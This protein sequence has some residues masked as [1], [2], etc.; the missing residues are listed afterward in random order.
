V[1]LARKFKVSIASIKRIAEELKTTPDDEEKP[2]ILDFDTYFELVNCESAK[3]YV[4]DSGNYYGYVRIR[5][6]YVGKIDVKL[7]NFGYK[8]LNLHFTFVKDDGKKTYACKHWPRN[9]TGKK[10]RLSYR[11]VCVRSYEAIDVT[12]IKKSDMYESDALLYAFI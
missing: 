4:A 11:G 6:E 1:C 7:S 3:V 2:K 5:D 9:A 12:G 8:H 10:R